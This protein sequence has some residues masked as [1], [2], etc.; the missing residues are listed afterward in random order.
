MILLSRFILN[1]W[2]AASKSAGPSSLGS[3]RLSGTQLDRIV[4]ELAFSSFDTPGVGGD[5]IQ[6]VMEDDPSG[7]DH[8]LDYQGDDDEQ[9]VVSRS[10]SPRRLNEGSSDS[11]HEG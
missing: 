11:R 9:G 4:G 3:S 5:T 7:P 2:E 6:D 10:P 1:L 8:S